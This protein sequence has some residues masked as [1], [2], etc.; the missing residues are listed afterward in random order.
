M[1]PSTADSTDVER[2]AA[3]GGDVADAGG[4]A[5][6]EALEQELDRR[7]AVVGADEHGR[8]VGVGD[9]RRLVPLLAAGAGEVVDGDAA[10]G[11]G[12]PACPGAELELGELGL[13]RRPR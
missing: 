13:A 4:E 10:V 7:R 2:H 1:S 5:G 8:V 6:G 12:D 11:A 9:E 3:D